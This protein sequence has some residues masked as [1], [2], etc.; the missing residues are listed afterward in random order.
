LGRR[1]DEFLARGL[2]G[3][4]SAYDQEQGR[5]G[6]YRRADL[7]EKRRDLMNAWTDYIIG[8]PVEELSRKAS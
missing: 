8:E 6:V 1:T 2:R 4:A 3:R 5:S 7:L